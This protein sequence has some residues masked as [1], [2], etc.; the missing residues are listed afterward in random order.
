MFD[1][2]EI[3]AYGTPNTYICEGCGCPLIERETREEFFKFMRTESSFK[4]EADR[5]EVNL[6]YVSYLYLDPKRGRKR[7][8]S[9]QMIEDVWGEESY[10]KFKE[11][12]SISKE[13]LQKHFPSIYDRLVAGN[14][15]IIFWCTAIDDEPDSILISD[16]E[17][18]FQSDIHLSVIL[19]QFLIDNLDGCIYPYPYEEQSPFEDVVFHSKGFSDYIE[20]V[21]DEL[22]SHPKINSIFSRVMLEIIKSYIDGQDPAKAAENIIKL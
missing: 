4:L 5:I 3:L 14:K 20:A 8:Y 2:Y 12:P 6:N 7:D 15:V 17:S 9:T 19:G 10:E 16:M 21:Y 13:T 11:Y 22:P 18:R 1:Q